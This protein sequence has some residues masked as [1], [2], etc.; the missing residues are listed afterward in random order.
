MIRRPP[1]STRT[2]T[3][4]PYTTLF[5]SGGRARGRLPVCQA[6]AGDPAGN[7][8][9]RFFR[10]HANGVCRDTGQRRLATDDRADCSEFVLGDR[11]SVVSV[12]S[13][14][15][16]V[17]L[18]GGRIITITLLGTS[19]KQWSLVQHKSKSL[20]MLICDHNQ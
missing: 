19:K 20:G 2:D 15:V 12:R 7:S 6:R 16:S 1:R 17:A 11:K 14:S 18:G 8:R 13:V 3:L 10:G 9:P 4:F 5:R